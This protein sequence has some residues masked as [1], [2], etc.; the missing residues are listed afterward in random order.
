MALTLLEWAKTSQNPLTLPTIRTLVEPNPVLQNLPFREIGGAAEVYNREESL[1]TV[2]FR[3]INESFAR[4]S[5]Y[6]EDHG[7]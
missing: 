5:L 7:I 6:R 2:A 4:W 1:P 3:A